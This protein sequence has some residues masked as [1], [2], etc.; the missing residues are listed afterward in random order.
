MKKFA[1]LLVSLL[2]FGFV[3]GSVFAQGV[4]ESSSEDLSESFSGGSLLDFEV[5]K[6]SYVASTSWVAAIAELAGIDDVITIAPA[7][8]KHP[9]EYEITPDDMVN[10]LNATLFMH[11]GYEKMMNTISN[12][13]GLNQDKIVKVKT[14]NTLENLSNMVSMLSAKAGTQEKAKERFGEYEKMIEEARSRIAASPNKD[15][16]VYANKNQ[17]QFAEDLGLNVVSTFGSGALTASQIEEASSK[18]YALVIDNLHSPVASP[19]AEVSP[20]SIILTWRNFPD[21]LGSNALYNVI[22]ENLDSLWSTG[23]F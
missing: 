11:A 9:P 19:I 10:V 2:V 21:H 13:A 6:A 17:S 15:I 23:L 8:L 18:A 1:L 16:E 7:N 4:K 5:S 3:C 14:T 22:K 20:S 12:A